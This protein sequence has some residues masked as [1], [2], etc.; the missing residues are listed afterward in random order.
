MY[1]GAVKVVYGRGHHVDDNTIVRGDWFADVE[2]A[3]H[4][5]GP[6]HSHYLHRRS[7]SLLRAFGSILG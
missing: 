3:R 4:E 5:V 7:L 6:G 2:Q 1:R